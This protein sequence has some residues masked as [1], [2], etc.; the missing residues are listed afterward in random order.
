MKKIK[1]ILKKPFIYILSISIV[2]KIIKLLYSYS[3]YENCKKISYGRN[4][5][6]DSVFNDLIVKN[7]PFKGMKYPDFISCG[8]S[9]YPKLLGFYEPELNDIINEI[10]AKK[11]TEILDIGCAEG[12]YAI[13][14]A[15]R[16]RMAK[17]F[18][19]DT[20]LRAIE[21]CRKMAELNN[22]GDR[23]QIGGFFD[24]NDLEN[25]N[26]TGRSLIICDCE[27]YE[28]VLFNTSNLKKLH[29][30]DLIIEFHD[31]TDPNISFNLLNLFSLTHEARIIRSMDDQLKFNKQISN[32]GFSEIKHLKLEDQFQAVAECRRQTMEWVYLTPKKLS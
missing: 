22:V 11:Y 25:F 19:Y 3:D 24:N 16:I 30:T 10:S 31:F 15:L 6:L 29:S 1:K 12:Y 21:Q 20:N 18:A 26:F 28:K 17:I 4:R 2:Y 5:N 23:L 27:G 8:S 13:G 32:Y 9:I 14:L 7:G